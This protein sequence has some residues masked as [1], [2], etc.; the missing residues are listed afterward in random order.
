MAIKAAPRIR[1]NEEETKR[2]EEESRGKES[3]AEQSRA[4]D[5]YRGQY[6]EDIDFYVTLKNIL[7]DFMQIQS[8]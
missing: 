3:R 2:R 6:R 7:F 8:H 4:V 5:K 1:D